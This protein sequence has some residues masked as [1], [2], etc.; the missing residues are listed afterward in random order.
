[1]KMCEEHHSKLSAPTLKVILT[2]LDHDWQG[3]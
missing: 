1:M 3:L 2:L